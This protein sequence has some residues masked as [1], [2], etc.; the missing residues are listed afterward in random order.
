[1]PAQI[2]IAHMGYA[3]GGKMGVKSHLGLD[4]CIAKIQAIIDKIKRLIL[5]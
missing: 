2:I 4:K 5:M 1:M 3:V